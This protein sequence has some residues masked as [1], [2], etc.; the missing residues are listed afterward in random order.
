ML[1]LDYIFQTITTMGNNF[2]V[3]Q[4]GSTDSADVTKLQQ[5]LKTLKLYTG[6]ADGLFGTQTKAAVIK[7]QQNHALTADG[8]VGYET[9]ASLE[10]DIWVAQRQTLQEGAANNDVKLLQTLLLQDVTNSG[11]ATAGVSLK[12]AIDGQ[13]GSHTKTN[14]IRFQTNHK[15]KPDGIVG[16]ATWKLLSS[17]VTFDNL[18]A[19]TIVGN[20]LFNV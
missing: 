17:V 3:L 16:L 8:V 4:E 7:F 12:Y 18:D 6:A 10:R 2:V 20:H 19:A 15:L 11:E 9:E 5:R 14:V 13:F 1:P